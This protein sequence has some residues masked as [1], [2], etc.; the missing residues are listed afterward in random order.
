MRGA[1]RDAVRRQCGARQVEHAGTVGRPD[2]EHRR[3]RGRLRPDH[4]R[5]C[6][7]GVERTAQPDGRVQPAGRDHLETLAQHG[8]VE[9]LVGDVPHGDR[10]VP[11]A[12]GPGRRRTRA[13]W[14]TAPR[15]RRGPTRSGA[16]APSPCAVLDELDVDP[17]RSLARCPG[18]LDLGPR[19]R[20]RGPPQAP[21]RASAARRPRVSMRLA[22]H[23][24]QPSAR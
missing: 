5:R 6:Q 20:G 21:P 24:D 23:E 17:G 4:H 22:R 8:R 1:D 7:A 14:R 19:R 2:L 3:L 11:L 13:G 18:H 16:R 12:P 9:V 10:G 15:R